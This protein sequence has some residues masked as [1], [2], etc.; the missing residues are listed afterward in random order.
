MV[1]N[2]ENE[3]SKKKKVWKKKIKKCEI[4]NEVFLADTADV[5]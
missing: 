2:K 3:N 5:P 1:S 4:K